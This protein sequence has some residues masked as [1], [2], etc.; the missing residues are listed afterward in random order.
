M[1]YAAGAIEPLGAEA[2]KADVIIKHSGVGA[3]DA[4]L[5]RMVLLCRSRA[6]RVVFWDVDAPATLARVAGDPHDPFRRLI[7]QYDSILTYGGGP[8]VVEQYLRLGARQCHP[9]YNGLDPATHFPVAPDPAL[10]CDL[11]FVGHRLPDRERRVEDFFLRAAWMAPELRCVLGGE[12]WGT[13]TLPPNVGW[14]GHV[15]TADHNRVNSSAR[16][17][18]NLNRDSMAEVG[19][20][21]PTRIFE[22]AGAAACVITDAWDGI[23]RFFSPGEE[24]LVARSAKEIVAH[25]RALTPARARTIGERMRA[26]ALREHTYGRRAAQAEPL[27][28]AHSTQ[29]PG[30]SMPGDAPQPPAGY[31]S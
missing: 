13:K 25:L 15:G 27:L 1:V 8:A 5:E 17:V 9:V 30:T 11:V 18:L 12:G 29:P 31:G 21:P 23:E 4:E 3:D 10:A 7:P 6:A 20:S 2:A 28:M 19:Y 16:A 22:A 24:I 14:I 26:R